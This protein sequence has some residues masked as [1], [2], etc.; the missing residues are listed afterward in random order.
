MPPSSD[1]VAIVRPLSADDIRR[2]INSKTAA[3][4]M[5]ADLAGFEF[6][7]GITSPAGSGG[8][9]RGLWVLLPSDE[10]NALPTLDRKEVPVIS[11]NQWAR[12]PEAWLAN[13]NRGGKG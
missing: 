9:L 1:R 6:R 7:D 8:V 11:S 4:T 3:L 12:I 13:A 10:Q 2:A 5:V